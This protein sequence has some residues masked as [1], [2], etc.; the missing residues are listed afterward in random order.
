MRALFLALLATCALALP[1][2]A[3]YNE[4]DVNI[5]IT[6]RAQDAGI[7][8]NEVGGAYIIMRDRRNGDVL[9]EGVTA[10]DSGDAKKIMG[11]TARDAVL[12]SD[13][14]ADFQ[15]S[16]AILEPLPVTVTARAPLVQ[17]QSE[18]TAS[19]DMI[20]IPGQDYSTGDGILI[21]VPGFIVNISE[22]AVAKTIKHDPN[23]TTD[24]RVHVAKLSGDAVGAKDGPWP[25]S[26]YK[27]Q[28]HIFKESVFATSAALTYG[29][30]PGLF[31]AKLKMPLPGTY[32]V[33]V[34]AFDPLTKESGIDSTTITFE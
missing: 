24:L 32:R 5:K 26:R 8:G 28:A 31:T 33:I 20:L 21:N 10:G 22:P 14:S 4:E 11:A 7:I 16:L 6:V 1:A 23:K 15:F 13:T 19:H 17:G 30:E 27:V 29:N 2:A 3:Q 34:S 12:S 9:A 25:E 18:I